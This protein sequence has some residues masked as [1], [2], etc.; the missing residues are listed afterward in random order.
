KGCCVFMLT[1]APPS[2]RPGASQSQHERLPIDADLVIFV[3][4]PAFQAL[5]PQIE[6]SRPVRNA[7]YGFFQTHAHIHT[8]SFTTETRRSIKLRISDLELMNSFCIRTIRNPQSAIKG[9]SV[10]PW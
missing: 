5:D 7:R 3:C 10:S 9:S 8:P 2:M 6:R 4:D 1:V